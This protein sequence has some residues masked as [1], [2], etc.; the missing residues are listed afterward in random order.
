MND[1]D[2]QPDLL[3]QATREAVE[4]LRKE[5]I[6]FR[7]DISNGLSVTDEGREA[8]ERYERE[9][10]RTLG[11]NT[12]PRTL[13]QRLIAR[14]QLII[15]RKESIWLI[16]L[17]SAATVLVILLENVLLLEGLPHALKLFGS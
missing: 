12:E 13:R 4:N 15:N 1:N 8:L 6:E 17:V 2:K 7:R 16:V 11:Q 10:F 3:D 14:L 9:Y 5:W